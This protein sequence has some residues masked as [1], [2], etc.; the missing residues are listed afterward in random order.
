MKLIINID[1]FGMSPGINQAVYEL[2][3][4]G[5]VK[6]TSL[7]PMA[8]YA[9]HGLELIVGL[10]INI[11]LHLT[12]NMYQP[13]STNERIKMTFENSYEIECLSTA[14]IYEEFKC[15]LD[16]FIALTDK[17]PTHLDTHYHLHLNHKN[18][19]DAVLE[20][21]KRHQ[22]PVRGFDADCKPIE[23]CSEFIGVNATNLFLENYL[24]R[25]IGAEMTNLE[26][27]SHASLEDGQLHK[28][29]SLVEPRYTEFRVLNSN[30]LKAFIEENN[31]ELINYRL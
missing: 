12:L 17:L 30:R 4:S 25:C 10:D 5:V 28:Y 2:G 24:K 31:I 15:Q 27:M 14:A 22:I 1:D 9:T 23:F 7:F 18:V 11:G 3:K 19:Q 13:C 29:T 20:L 8:N 6:S 26:I 21:A 16:A